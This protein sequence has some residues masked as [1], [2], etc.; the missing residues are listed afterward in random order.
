V[1]DVSDSMNQTCAG[2]TDGRTEYVELGYS[3]L[4]LIKHALRT[5]VLTMRPVDRLALVTFNQASEVAFGFT[6]MSE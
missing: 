3:L 6:E 4:D 2:V 5:V 1:V